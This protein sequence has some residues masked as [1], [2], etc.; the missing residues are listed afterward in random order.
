MAK[1]WAQH[2]FTFSLPI[3]F[4][5]AWFFPNLACRGGWLR[6]EITT[7]LGVILIFLIQGLLL[8][9]QE[10][11]N[12]LLNW[13]FHVLVQGFV[14]LGFP[15]LGLL[16][17]FLLGPVLPADLRVGLLYL[18]VLPS[19]I[20]SASILTATA[21]GNVA[22]AVCAAILSSLLGV[23]LT[24]VWAT[25]TLDVAGHSVAFGPVVLTLTKLIV[26]PLLVGQ[27]LRLT[28]IRGWSDVRKKLL[29]MVGTCVIL[30]IVFAAFCDAA[31]SR[32]W[33]QQGSSLILLAFLGAVGLF[34]I[35]SGLVWL[36]SRLVNLT[37]ADKKAAQFCAVQKTL[38][39]GVPMAALIFGQHPGLGIILLP[40]LI[41]HPLQLAVQGWLAARWGASEN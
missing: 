5:V 2:W 27:V 10:L 6:P 28:P 41:Y 34:V 18:C 31:K 12:G 38:A 24:P 7:Q 23:I 39:S 37:L 35:A 32:I 22:A 8:P 17:A 25:A 20:S 21:R 29:G 30:F 4:F 1:L 14:F 26:L 33:T 15:L 19:T 9:T 16:V 13:R 11:R 40:L 3:A 36:F